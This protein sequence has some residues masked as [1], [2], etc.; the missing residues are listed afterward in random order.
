[1]KLVVDM[2]LS[3]DWVAVLMQAGWGAVHWS[4]FGNPRAADS[5][6]MAW[7]KQNN[8]VIFTHDLDFGTTLALT[9]AEGPSVIQVRTQD[10]TPAAIGKIVVRT[11]QQFQSELKKG[12]LI[13]LD[14]AA[15]RARI[16]PLKN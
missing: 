10:V 11:L 7:A 12:A 4:N 2:N 5:E 16:L 6:I 3:P 1:M 8:H 9:Q 13:V 15:I 14:E